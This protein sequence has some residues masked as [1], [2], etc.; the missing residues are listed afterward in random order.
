LPSYRFCRPDE[1]GD[2]V[3]AVN[4]CFNVHFPG[5]RPATVESFRGEMKRLDVWPSN[6][7]VAIAGEEPI[8]VLIG[9]KRDQEVLVLRV[10]V[11]PDHAGQ[12]HGSH[13]LT[14]LSQKLAVLGPPR[15]IAEVPQALPGVQSFFAAAGYR[16][17]ATYTDYRREPA[18][19]EGVPEDLV[20]PVSV[21]DLV[22]NEAL[23]LLAGRSW[24]RSR[25]TLLNRRQE[26]TGFAVASPERLE[27][28][29]LYDPA[30]TAAGLEIVALGSAGESARGAVFLGLLLR[31]L[32][33]RSPL[34]LSLPRL[35][36]GEVPAE[37]LA[38]LGFH[39]WARF[40]RLAT[41]ATPA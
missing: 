20:I 19:V 10:G 3:R 16:H 27:A 2:V 12:G 24:V 6:C 25:E 34:P 32:A 22:D 8:A 36:A 33:G 21:Q 4:D 38:E 41:A 7:M 37:L 28:Y 9:T 17:E 29:L 31:Y 18:P 35:A 40:D 23:D 13:V 14:S 5:A 26:L 30:P 15:L 1:E 39:P 11:R